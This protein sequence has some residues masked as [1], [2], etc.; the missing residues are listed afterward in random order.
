VEEIPMKKNVLVVLLVLWVLFPLIIFAQEKEKI[1]KLDDLPRFTYQVTGTVTEMFT[2]DS[3]FNDFATKVRSDIEG[4]L[5]KYDIEDNTTLK[6]LYGL[7]NVF[8]MFDKNYQKVLETTEFLRNLDEKPSDKLTRGLATKSIVEAREGFGDNEQQYREAFKKYY[9]EQVNALPWD[10]VQDDIESTKGRM[11]IMSENLMLGIIQSSIEPAVEKTGNISGDVANQLVGMYYTVKVILPLKNEIVEVLQAYIDKNKVVKPDIWADR[12]VDLTGNNNISP[13]VIGIWDSGVD[14][15]IYKNNLFTNKKEK[16]DGKD[17][18]GN[19]FIDDVHGIAF[20]LHED[21]SSDLL[22][23]LTADQL[24][25]YPD[26]KEQMK[27]LEDLQAAVESPEAIG[28]KK[29][30]SGMTPD[31][32]KPFLEEIGLFAIYAHGT[33]VAGI[34]AAGNPAARILVSRITFDYHVIPEA[35]TVELAKKSGQNYQ[36]TVDYF[37]AHNV[38]VV[39]MSW[40]TSLK[41]VESDLEANGIGKDSDERAKLAREIFDIYHDGLYNALKS[42]PDILFVIAAGNEDN[43][44]TFDEVIP[45]SFDL[46]NVLTVGAV[47]QAGEETGFTSFG[48]SV[49]VYANGFEVKSYIPGGEQLALS[50]TSMAAPNVTNLA[51]KLFAL[52]PKLSVTQVVELIRMGADVSEDGRIILI[53]PQKSVELMTTTG[54]Q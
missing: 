51:G 41:E 3:L 22:F 17:D 36:E 6:R 45:S 33:H 35:P 39:N 5:Q 15:D 12:S 46:P 24:Q 27:G 42:A 48:K 34:A 43:D 32:V 25:K 13:V 47:D 37:K 16:P 31:Q 26:M 30:M 8:Y 21:K 4:V 50:G 9:A 52:D 40:G 54:E 38:R 18:D 11:E 19:G 10:I 29:K 53:N 2:N 23:P 7:M 44:V 20:T 14:T 28:L 1:T 49:D